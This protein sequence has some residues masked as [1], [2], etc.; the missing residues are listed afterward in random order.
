LAVGLLAGNLDDIS[1][2]ATYGNFDRP[3]AFTFVHRL[4]PGMIDTAKGQFYEFTREIHY[5]PLMAVGLIFVVFWFVRT[6]GI[7]RWEFKRALVQWSVFVIT[8]L[9]VLRVAQ[10]L[11]LPRCAF[12]SYPFLTCEACEMATGA[13]PIGTLQISLTRGRLPTFTLGVMIL[14][15]VLF[16]RAICGWA[17][18]MGLFMDMAGRFMGQRKPLPRWASA[19]KFVVLV[20]M[21]AAVVFVGLAGLGT[22]LPFCSTLCLGGTIYGLIPYYATT[23]KGGYAHLLPAGIMLLVFHGAVFGAF[24]LLSRRYTARF[25][26]RAVCPLGAFLGLFYRVSVVRVRHNPDR[27]T[28]CGKCRSACPM[29][30]D[31]GRDD[32][33]T[34]SNCIRCGACIHVCPHE[35]RS[36]VPGRTADA[37]PVS[38]RVASPESGDAKYSP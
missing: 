13:C 21:L 4:L 1:S 29:D 22:V 18:P 2:E 20:T 25:F 10:V 17:C 32:F 27:C 11:P 26:C 23:A 16:G 19:M 36:W 33:L 30:I 34:Q 6:L 8:R 7:R 24:L 28:D 12:G 37:E 3:S 35:A 38:S 9:G 15:G 5:K 14:G 31:L